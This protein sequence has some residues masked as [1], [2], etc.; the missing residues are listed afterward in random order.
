MTAMSRKTNTVAQ[1][2]TS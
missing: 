2:Q 1:Y